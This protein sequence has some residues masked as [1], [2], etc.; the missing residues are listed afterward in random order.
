MRSL[1]GP[2]SKRRLDMID[3]A[4]QRLDRN[5]DN[6]VT[7]AEIESIYDASQHPDVVAGRRT[8]REVLTEFMQ[9]WDKIRPDSVI[10]KDEFVEYYRDVSASIDTDDYFELMMRNSWHISGGNGRLA[11]TSCRRVLVHHTDGRQTVEEIRND[12]GLGAD[13]VVE[14][15]RRLRQQGITDI[16]RVSLAK[17]FKDKDRTQFRPPSLTLSPGRPS[18]GT[19]RPTKSW[20]ENSRSPHRDKNNTDVLSRPHT[21]SI[22]RQRP[23]ATV[24]HGA[25]LEKDLVLHQQV[26]LSFSSD[27]RVRYG[28]SV[29]LRNFNTGRLLACDA[30]ADPHPHSKD[31]VI[32]ARDSTG[33]ATACDTF[34]V[35]NS[36]PGND[37]KVVRYGDTVRLEINPSLRADTSAGYM[38]PPQYVKSNGRGIS[39]GFGGKSAQDVF[40]SATADSYAAW[41]LAPLDT[42]SKAQRAKCGNPILAD[43]PLVLI[44]V[45]SQHC[46][47]DALGKRGPRPKTGVFLQTITRRNWI[48]EPVNRWLVVLAPNPQLAVDQRV[49]PRAVHRSVKTVMDT[50]RATINR[51]GTYAIRGL[52]RSFR[53]MDT[54]HDHRLQPHE[55][56]DGLRRYR[57]HLSD[58]EFEGLMKEVD[59]NH[60]GTVDFDEVCVCE[61]Y[62]E[63]CCS[64][65]SVRV[66][67]K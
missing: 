39:N 33:T 30:F 61:K 56:R 51:R 31:S 29:Q 9:Q 50:V 3:L 42:S 41:K 36:E 67:K 63:Y 20:V 60:D 40:A 17:D 26:P 25:G 53:I 45:C 16:K 64:R 58:A 34:V 23:H 5:G 24:S 4:F 21:A 43:D 13:D 11:N 22:T 14:M 52:G 54:N 38:R 44:H 59:R 57:V 6:Q 18:T 48:A 49:F 2:L 15:T 55:L 27:G 66:S 1:R 19:Q 28:F 32:F 62:C 65:N 8:T 37:G 46:L 35:Q 10:T 12:L 47:G 7:L